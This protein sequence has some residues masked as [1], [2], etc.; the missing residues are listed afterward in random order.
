MKTRDKVLLGWNMVV[1]LTI[2]IGVA[3]LF[4]MIDSRLGLVFTLIIPFVFITG[5]D[6]KTKEISAVGLV[7]FIIFY[8][9]YLAELPLFLGLLLAMGLAYGSLLY[10]SKTRHLPEQLKLGLADVVCLPVAF[11]AMAYLGPLPLAVG[12]LAFGFSMFQKFRSK[13][14]NW[15]LLPAMF[16]GL[17]FAFVS[18]VAVLLLIG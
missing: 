6:S 17:V 7:P 15:A 11:S 1:F 3:A 2:I 4:S 10:I 12:T 16:A 13:K 5:Q 8:G 18:G 14:K 9:I